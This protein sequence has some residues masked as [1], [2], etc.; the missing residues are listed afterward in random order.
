VSYQKILETAK[1]ILAPDDDSPA[2]AVLLSEALDALSRDDLMLV[3]MAQKLLGEGAF[4]ITTD[5]PA[6][7]A[8]ARELATIMGAT[9]EESRSLPWFMPPEAA[10]QM[11]TLRFMLPQRS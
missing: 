8:R 1:L 7:W 2:Y 3:M 9:V 11:T 10:G 4:L 6:S 5:N